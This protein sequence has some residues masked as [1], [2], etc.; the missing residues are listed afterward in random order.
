MSEPMETGG[1][2][3]NPAIDKINNLNA[4]QNRAM[5]FW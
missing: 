2:G 1:V 5:L 4:V 3:K